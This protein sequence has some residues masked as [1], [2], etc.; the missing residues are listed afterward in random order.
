MTDPKTY[1]ISYEIEGR[2]HWFDLV[3]HSHADCDRKL[4]AIRQT[5]QVQG[6]LISRIRVNS[7]TAPFWWAY[8]KLANLWWKL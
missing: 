2:V 8:G 6:E 4:F 1:L 5:A 3:A 7:I